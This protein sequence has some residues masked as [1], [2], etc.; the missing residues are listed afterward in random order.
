MNIHS[1]TPALNGRQQSELEST[2]RTGARLYARA[3]EVDAQIEAMRNDYGL[4]ELNP[5]IP[6]TFIC[7]MDEWDGIGT[8][9]APQKHWRDAE[10][11][12]FDALDLQNF[13]ENVRK[14]A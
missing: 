13:E 6:K 11:R 10:I 12:S 8:C 7:K 3:E 1:L 9:T 14:S 4:G 2:L 5:D